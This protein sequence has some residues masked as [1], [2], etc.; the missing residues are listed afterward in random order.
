MG[1]ARPPCRGADQGAVVG[2]AR[3]PAALQ[4]RPALGDGLDQAR[5]GLA[6]AHPGHGV[7]DG[8]SWER[9]DVDTDAAPLV[10]ATGAL[11]LASQYRNAAAYDPLSNI[12]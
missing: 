7:V 6:L 11:A 4:Q 5:R 9:R 12:W 10:A 3:H 8:W 1:P 2:P